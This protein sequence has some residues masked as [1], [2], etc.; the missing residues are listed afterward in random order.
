[1]SAT[2]SLEEAQRRYLAETLPDSTP[3]RIDW[4][5]GST[6]VIKVGNGPPVLLLHGGL[7][8]AFQ[9]APL[10][11]VLA[12]R[13]RLIA[14][15]RPG[16]GLAAPFD[17]G[18]KPLLHTASRFIEEFLDAEGLATAPIVA[19]SMGGLWAAA[20]AL[21][22]PQ[23]VSRLVL[24]GSPAGI[25]RPIPLMLRVGMVPGIKTLIRRAMAQPTPQAVRDFWSLLVAHP[26]RLSESFIA[27][28]T[29]SQLRN[30][31]SWFTLLD[32]AVGV[33]G[34]KREL[35]LGDA[36]RQLKPPTTFVWG[37][38]DRWADIRAAEAVVAANA[39]ARLVRIADAGHAPWFDRP[40]AVATAV[41]AALGS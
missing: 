21:E 1:M 33:A 7:G 30:H 22:R 25:A 27:A 12:P 36:W 24:V 37:E 40:Q 28:S 32:A 18:T 11:A 10:M 8:D 19:N 17:Y 9:W 4:S 16:H 26:E 41:A 23:R 5:G 39:S 31:P 38:M 6:Q 2:T 20:F 15:D 14:V 3:R 35:V 13:Y 29:A 34:M